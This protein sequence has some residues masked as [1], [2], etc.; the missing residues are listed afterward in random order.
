VY[1][2][3]IKLEQP[4]V[5]LI[6]LAEDNN[7]WTFQLAG[8]QRTSGDSAPSS[9]SFRLD[10]ILFDRGTI[11]IDD[12]ITRSDITILVDPLG[13]P[14]PFSEVTGTKDRH[15]A[16]K[17]GD[18]VFGLSLKGRYKGQPVTGNGKIGGMLALRSASTLS[19]C[20]ATSTPATPGWRS[21]A[22]SATRSTSAALTCG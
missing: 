16:A 14:L 9:W 3:W 17:P 22:R 1:L 7:N 4:D 6:R 13:K 15:S 10:N 19:R 12:K 5:R 18:Y 8:D 11:A 20:R 2:P 21:A